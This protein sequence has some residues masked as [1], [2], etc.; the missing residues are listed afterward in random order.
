MKHCI[1]YCTSSSLNR[2]LD[3]ALVGCS[4]EAL[5]WLLFVLDLTAVAKRSCKA[6][7]RFD[8]LYPE[9]INTV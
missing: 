9:I 8:E 5:A 6:R 1:V 4:V 2:E 3:T 7:N